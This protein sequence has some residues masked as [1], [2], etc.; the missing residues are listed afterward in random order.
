MVGVLVHNKSKVE[1]KKKQGSC[2][3]N[4]SNENTIKRSL[5]STLQTYSYP[6]NPA[7]PFWR[8]TTKN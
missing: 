5:S 3:S 7:A 6:F 1:K 8:Q 2:E 4:L